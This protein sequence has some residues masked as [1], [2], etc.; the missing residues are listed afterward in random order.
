MR[1]VKASLGAQLMK[2][3]D[4]D[5]LSMRQAEERTGASYHE[6]SRIQQAKFSRFTI[7]RLISILG[8][9]GQ[10]V[11]FSMTMHPRV[12]WMPQQIQR[13]GVN[14]GKISMPCLWF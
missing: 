2:M 6:F 8:R 10:E 4:K 5:G 12:W 7:D 11:N 1:Q 13:Q 14:D 9:L 3:L